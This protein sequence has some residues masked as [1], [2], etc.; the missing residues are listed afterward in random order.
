MSVLKT[1]GEDIAKL[2]EQYQIIEDKWLDS[3]VGVVA[4]L[5]EFPRPVFVARIGATEGISH[6]N[7]MY[8][9]AK[10]GNKLDEQI[11]RAIFPRLAYPYKDR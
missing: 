9:I 6:K 3:S 1:D 11:A 2:K 4:V 5:E 7:E 8:I 10:K